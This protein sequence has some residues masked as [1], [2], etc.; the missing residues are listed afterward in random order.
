MRLSGCSPLRSSPRAVVP[1]TVTAG[2]PSLQ[3]TGAPALI[4]QQG[5]G[6]ENWKECRSESW[7][8][9]GALFAAPVSPFSME[10]SSFGALFTDHVPAKAMR[11]IP[12]HTA[13]IPIFWF[14][15]FLLSIY[16]LITFFSTI[17]AMLEMQ[18]VPATWL[19]YTLDNH[20]HIRSQWPISIQ[21][22]TALKLAYQ[23]GLYWI[24][25]QG[26]TI[27]SNTSRRG[28]RAAWTRIRMFSRLFHACVT[29]N[30]PHPMCTAPMLSANG[31]TGIFQSLWSNRWMFGV[32][33]CFLFQSVSFCSAN[34][35]SFTTGTKVAYRMAHPY[36]SGTGKDKGTAACLSNSCFGNK[37]PSHFQSTTVIQVVEAGPSLINLPICL[38]LALIDSAQSS[39]S[40]GIKNKSNQIDVGPT[41]S[42]SLALYGLTT[43]RSTAVHPNLLMHAG[44]QAVLCSTQPGLRIWEKTAFYKW[45]ALCYGLVPR[46]A[47]I[48]L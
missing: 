14:F 2:S 3:H 19:I 32:D 16:H 48:P 6:E 47:H 31:K 30:A 4:P 23:Y 26:K 15:S 43:C 12:P 33:G 1:S 46:P 7:V 8:C 25:R 28:N 34:F 42:C 22:Y 45:C 20:M 27:N 10:G 21:E 38:G 24:N 35:H 36:L 13:E 39:C 17:L 11:Q 41:F 40:L 9:P 18:T 29:S 5:W 44:R 37:L